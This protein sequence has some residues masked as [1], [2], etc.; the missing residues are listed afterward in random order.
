M[1]HKNP[2]FCSGS[3]AGLHGAGPFSA[4]VVVGAG[5]DKRRE[6]ETRVKGWGWASVWP[7]WETR[8]DVPRLM[9]GA[10]LLLFPSLAEGL[11]MVVVRSAAAGLRCLL[12]TRHRAS[13]W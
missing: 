4:V 10:D 9:L 11:G 12:R 5:E 13:V 3:G 7:S 2:R 1:S 8:H 6:F